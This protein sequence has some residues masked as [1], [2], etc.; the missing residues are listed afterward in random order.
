MRSEAPLATGLSVLQQPK[1]HVIKRSATRGALWTHSI[2]SLFGP[3][4]ETGR[5]L[6]DPSQDI[7][8]QIGAS[9]AACCNR[10]V[11]R[12]ANLEYVVHAIVASCPAGVGGPMGY[13]TPIHATCGG[14]RKG[15]MRSA[16]DDCGEVRGTW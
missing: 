6:D 7:A 9:L 5:D 16:S 14:W 13:G 4:V 10:N 15:R 12:D 3:G 11:G 8:K 2:T 1:F